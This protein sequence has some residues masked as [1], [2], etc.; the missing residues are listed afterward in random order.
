MKTMINNKIKG[1]SERGVMEIKYRLYI[2]VIEGVKREKEVCK[3]QHAESI[4][5]ELLN[6]LGSSWTFTVPTQPDHT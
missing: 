5:A 3:Q 4:R 6:R 2:A 1:G